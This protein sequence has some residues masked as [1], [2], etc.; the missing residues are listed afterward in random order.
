MS[1][2]KY[3]PEI[4][5]L[6]A[7]AVVAVIVYHARADWLPGGFVGVDIFFVISGYLI[8]SIIL[9]QVEEGRFSFLE[10]YE[11]RLRRIIPALLAMLV[12]TVGVFAIIALPEQSLRTA[13]SAVAALLSVSN[14]YFWQE[15]SYFAPSAEFMPLLHT[16]TLGVEEQFYFLFPVVVIVL[17]KFRLPLK[18]LLALGTVASFFLGYWLSINKPSVAFFLLPARAWE[19]GIGVCLAAGVV[20]AIRS[21]RACNLVSAAGIGLI[22]LSLFT[23]RSSMFF[24][25]WVALMPC[26]GAAMVIHAGGRSSLARALLANRPMVVTGLMSYS[27]YLWHW[28]VLTAFRIRTADIDLEIGSILLAIV[29]TLA[30]SWLSWVYVEQP[31]R[32]RK[33]RTTRTVLSGIG[34]GSVALFSMAGVIAAANGF[35]ERLNPRARLAL[36]ASTDIDPYRDRC[37]GAGDKSDCKFGDQSAPVTYAIVGDSHA[38]ALRPAIEASGL[39]RDAA[40]TLYFLGAC[41]FLDGAVKQRGGSECEDFKSSAWSELEANPNLDTVVLAARWPYQLLGTLPESGGSSTEYVVDDETRSPGRAENFRVFDR[42]LR[43][44]LQRLRSRG[45]DVIVVGS[46]PEPGFDVPR[47]V[48][49]AELGDTEAP[50]G[51]RT[52]D[53]MKRAGLADRLIERVVADYPGVRFLPIWPS[54]CDRERCDVQR[55]GTPIYYDDDHLS[56]SFARTEMASKLA[57]AARSD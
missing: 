41:P 31:F 48:A 19:L 16:W 24:P 10:F 33:V 44:T 27:L 42:A 35:P 14:F 56:Y 12:V 49:L 17:A 57:A 9:R 37:H 3:R 54:L 43:R 30:V 21:D 47:T 23:I 46:V 28:P 22:L 20:P 7:I 13:E 36:E 2:L 18:W 25:G 40:G 38:A 53:V 8:S 32:S 50:R 55:G 6:R 4:D 1:V 26:I 34:I 15:S 11:R 52:S 5:G 51:V 45:L 39:M 29:V